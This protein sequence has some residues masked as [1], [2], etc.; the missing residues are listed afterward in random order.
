MWSCKY[1]QVGTVGLVV[2]TQHLGKMISESEYFTA[3]DQELPLKS[4]DLVLGY[5]IGYN[6]CNIVTY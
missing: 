6:G 2:L 3:C 4:H 1:N 5:I